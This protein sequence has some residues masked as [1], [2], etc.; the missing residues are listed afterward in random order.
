MQSLPKTLV[1][2]QALISQPKASRLRD[3][4]TEYCRR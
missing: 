4:Y 3:D 2:V 1:E